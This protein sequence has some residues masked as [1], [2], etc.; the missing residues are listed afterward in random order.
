[1]P[2]FNVK[3]RD[4]SELANPLRNDMYLPITIDEGVYLRGALKLAVRNMKQGDERD[5]TLRVLDRLQNMLLDLKSYQN[6]PF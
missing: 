1:M 2:Q 3:K 5:F 4:D 6:L